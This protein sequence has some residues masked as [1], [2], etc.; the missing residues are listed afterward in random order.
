MRARA[1]ACVRTSLDLRL[2]LH[3]SD[4]AKK[5]R[6]KVL[7][8]VSSCAQRCRKKL[9]GLRFTN[10][11]CRTRHV[12]TSTTSQDGGEKCAKSGKSARCPWLLLQPRWKRNCYS[13][14][15]QLELMWMSSLVCVCLLSN[16]KSQLNPGAKIYNIYKYII[17]ETAQSIYSEHYYLVF[18][19]FSFKTVGEDDIAVSPF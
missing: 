8:P 4:R 19:T 1:R 16:V 11:S 3:L 2:I 6:E 17:Y 15:I 9:Q 14:I 7:H 12:K 5:V 13:N 10:C 18:Y